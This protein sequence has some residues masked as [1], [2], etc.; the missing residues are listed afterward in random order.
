M[1]ATGLRISETISL[2]F[3]NIDLEECIV[4]VMGKGSKER[5]VPINDYAIEALEDYLN[6]YRPLLVKNSDTNY[7]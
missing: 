4:R 6:N 5:I 7:F 2:E 1:Y 3:K